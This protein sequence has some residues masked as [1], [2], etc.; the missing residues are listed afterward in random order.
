MVE[1]SRR[2]FMGAVTALALA[3]YEAEGLDPANVDEW[4]PLEPWDAGTWTTGEFEPTGMWASGEFPYSAWDL[5]EILD[6]ASVEVFYDT[7]KV[8]LAFENKDETSRIGAHISLPPDE[9][10]ELAAALYQAAW[11]LDNRQRS[12]DIDG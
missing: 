5:D 3:R 1:S 4:D 11:E 12:G 7:E 8:L 10:M 2:Q 9:V 6:E